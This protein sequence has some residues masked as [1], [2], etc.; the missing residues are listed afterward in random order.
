[1]SRQRWQV[2]L[3][4]AAPCAE[5][6]GVK[7]ENLQ[8]QQQRQQRQQQQQQQQQPPQ[9]QQQQQ[10][11]PLPTPSNNP[12]QE[13]N[14]QQPVSSL[15]I[16]AQ[17]SMHRLGGREYPHEVQDAIGAAIG[18]GQCVICLAREATF[19]VEK[20]GH[21]VSCTP[22]RR[23]LVHEERIKSG[24]GYDTNRARREINAKHLKQTPVPCPMCRLL[25]R[26]ADKAKF[27]GTV[28]VCED[29]DLDD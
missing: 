28:F 18:R 23:R 8:Q 25:G 20:C 2:A 10:Q 15:A 1:M 7:A 27:D 17:A 11:Q 14:K 6:L 21:L 22:C 9:P 16:A 4:S 12:F 5:P 24:L 13:P 19:V 26:L 29:L 3:R